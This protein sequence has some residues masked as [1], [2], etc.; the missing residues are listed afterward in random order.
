MYHNAG[1]MISTPRVACIDFEMGINCPHSIN[2][3]SQAL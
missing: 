1:M 3:L 2:Y